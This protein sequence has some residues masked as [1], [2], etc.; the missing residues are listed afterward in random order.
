MHIFFSPTA[1]LMRQASRCR[2]NTVMFRWK[3]KIHSFTT[4]LCSF[5][6]KLSAEI[7]IS[8]LETHGDELKFRPFGFIY[9]W[10]QT[11]AA[12]KK[13]FRPCPEELITQSKYGLRALLKSAARVGCRARQTLCCSGLLLRPA[14]AQKIFLRTSISVRM[15]HWRLLLAIS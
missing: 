15:M 7:Q 1:R 6:L 2:K 5:I 13:T 9:S 14:L 4:E 11:E 10:N 8:G 3:G 12:E